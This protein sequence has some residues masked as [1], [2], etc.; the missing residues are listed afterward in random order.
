MES[1]TRPILSPSKALNPVSPERMNQ[2]NIPA[3][4]SLPSDLLTLHHKST[5]GV[6]EVQA[7][8]AFLN[9]LSRG[10]SP[11]N[12]AANNAALQRAILGRE[13]AESALATAQEDLSE[14]QTRERRISERLES[15]LEELH[16]TKERQA[17]E[18]S[19]FEK[20]IRKAR[21]EAFRAGSTLVKLQE[22]LK[23]AKSEVRALKDEVGA[24]REAKDKA[25]QEAFERAYALAGLTEEL[26]VL[27]EKFRAL[28]T[29]NR[30]STLEVRAHEIR[31]EDFG[32]LSI[33]EGDLAF[34]TTPR[35]PKRAAAGS[36]RSPAPTRQEDHAE[37]TPPKRPRL[38][39]F[40][41][42]TES[43]QPESEA[44]AEVDEDLLDGMKEELDFE[45]RR[46]VAA[47]DMVHFLNI[48]CQFERCS[49]RL[50]ES[51]G[52][53]YIYDAEYY[54]NFQKP[55]IEAEEK[56][57]AQQASIQQAR[58]D[59]AQ[60]HRAST[61]EASPPPPSSTSQHFDTSG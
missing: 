35:R 15:L 47:E 23:Q 38:S 60:S 48:E 41:P 46:R 51:Q 49:C 21:K 52:R 58:V 28:E 33:A 2:Q 59:Q 1:P 43:K 8:V 11:A 9:G 6:S 50:A 12:S 17:H 57:R 27:K 31:K 39:D 61:P 4:P 40:T 30:S 44:G 45:R 26:E 25:K 32:R 10:G 13:E 55:Q 37:A 36:V 53:R 20:E 54:H 24:E 18:R 3:S 7:K 16:G 5:R 56:F 22:E 14:A 42:M 34:L 29:D 19:I